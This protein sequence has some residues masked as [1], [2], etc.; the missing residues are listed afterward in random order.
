MVMQNIVL[1]LL[2]CE[3]DVR[4]INAN[5]DRPIDVAQSEDITEALKGMQ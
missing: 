5:G 4:I 3:A 2:R 1:E